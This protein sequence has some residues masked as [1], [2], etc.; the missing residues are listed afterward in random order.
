ME[1]T[2]FIGCMRLKNDHPS[3][4]ADL[5]RPTADLSAPGGFHA[6]QGKKVNSIIAPLQSLPIYLDIS[7]TS[8]HRIRIKQR[9][10]NYLWNF[11]T[12]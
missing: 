8:C 1:I 3:V 9:T 6:I 2:E 4:G 11:T 7:L 5:S 12:R 10:G